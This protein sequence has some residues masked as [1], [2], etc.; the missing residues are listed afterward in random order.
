MASTLEKELLITKEKGVLTFKID[1]PKKK[2]ALTSAILKKILEVMEL[3]KT[4]ETVKVIYLTAAGEIFSSGND[5]NNFSENTFDETEKNLEHFVR[6]LIEY[7]K[8]MIA[9]VNGMAMG[10]TFTMLALFDIVLCSD[11]AFFLVPFIQT[12]QTPEGCSSLLFP[13]LL[14]KSTAS[15][16]LINGGTINAIE[17]KEKGFVTRVIEKEYFENDAYDYAL[18]VAEH[19]LKQLV[20]IKKIIN[21]NFIELLKE[22]N[23]QEC[24]SLRESWDQPEFKNII[25]K[26]VKNPKF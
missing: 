8:V 22:V 10:I 2:N 5:F 9:G 7:P 25:K 15:H 24:K 19:P 20:T 4:D 26:F 1:R 3:A 12:Y 17:A 14:G 21:R 23:K 16:L 13:L 18:K 11:T 6:Y